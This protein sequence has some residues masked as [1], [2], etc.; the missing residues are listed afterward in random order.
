MDNYQFKLLTQDERDEMLAQTL[1]NQEVDI[2]M[3]TVNK[4]RYQQIIPQLA[5][6]NQLRKKLE[7]DVHDIDNRLAEI[8]AIITALTPQL[9]PLSRLK[10]AMSRLEQKQKEQAAEK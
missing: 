6:D 7:K 3:H 10:A 9:P 5:E 1:K 8:G 2:F 4:S